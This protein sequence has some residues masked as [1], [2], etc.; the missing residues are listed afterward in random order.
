M[1][2]VVINAL[3]VPDEAR[4]TLE[5]RFAARK[6]AVDQAPGFEG[7]KLLRPTAGEDRYFVFTQWASR[8]DFEHW[9]DHGAA[10]AHAHDDSEQGERAKPAAQ[11]A[12]L[13][14]FEIVDL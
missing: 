11:S 10:A 7:F 5:Q 1:S 6:H 14:E 2:I 9:R 8:Q 3:T 12:E 4:A 13:L